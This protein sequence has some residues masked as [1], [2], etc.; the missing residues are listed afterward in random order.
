[1]S[2]SETSEATTFPRLGISTQELIDEV[3]RLLEQAGAEDTN[4]MGAVNWG[5]LGVADI[6]YRLSIMHPEDGPV[7][8]VMV[9]E[10]SPHSGLAQ[11][12][13]ERLDKELFPN[14]R[15]ECEW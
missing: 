3:R 15:I 13:N 1:M 6:E 12:L 10:A 11:W 14:T 9:E 8:V 5:D 2:G 4:E 7:C